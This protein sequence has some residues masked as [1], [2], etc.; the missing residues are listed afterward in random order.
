MIESRQVQRLAA[1]AGWLGLF[2][3]AVLSLVPGEFRPHTDLPGPA[4]HILAYALTGTALAVGYPRTWH[5]I[6]WF[7]AMSA[8]GVLFEILQLWIPGRS[9]SVID[10]T[11]CS[12][13]TALGLFFGA[14]FSRLWCANSE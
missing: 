5:R 4:E 6:L 11:A 7:L 13:G 14:L 8:A 10:V 1:L 2:V 3:I 12:S 9:P